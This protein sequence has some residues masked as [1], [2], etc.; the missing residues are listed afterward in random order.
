MALYR[1]EQARMSFSSEAAP[2]GYM[3]I[4]GITTDA[5][6]WTGVMNNTVLASGTDSAS[7]TAAFLTDTTAS[8]ITAGVVPG[9]TILNTTDTSTG[10]IISLTANTVVA[11]MSSGTWASGDG[12]SIQ[13]T[14]LP[15]SRSVTFDGAS[16]TLAV[17]NY[18][19]LG[20]AGAENAEIRR[21]ISLGSYGG[22]A[23]T[24][25][26]F[27]D[28]PTGFPHV[29]NSLVDEK[30]NAFPTGSTYTAADTGGSPQGTAGD[31][32][33]NFA[34]FLPGVYESI[35]TPDLTPEFLPQYFLRDSNTRNWSYMYRGKQSF[36][37]SL[38]NILLLNGQPLK[39]PFG[40]VATTAGTKSN[41]D[42]LNGGT[43]VGDRVINLTSGTGYTAGKW[44][45]IDTDASNKAEVRQIL[46]LST[47]TLTLNYPLM[48]THADGVA[49]YEA[50]GVYTHTM[51]E[52]AKLPTMTWNVLM[53][54][55]DE[56][57]DNDFIRR[58][59]GGICN[60]ATL[61]GAEG[62]MLRYSWDDVQFMDLVH[63]QTRHSS[64]TGDSATADLMANSSSMLL[65]PLGIGADMPY[66]VPATGNQVL[67]TP[68]YPRTEPYYFSQG[69]LSFFGVEFARIV[70]FSLQIS[71][72]VEAKYYVSD[73]GGKRIPSEFIEKNR[74]Y[75]M[76]VSIAL[77]DSFSS[78]STTKSLWKELILEG[79]YRGNGVQALMGFD[80]SLT[81]T[82]DTNE[83]ITIT[84]PSSNASTSFDSQGCFF[85]RATHN[86]DQE[87]PL[88]VD[89]E[90]IMRDCKVV[91]ID[92]IPVYA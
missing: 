33:I 30:T 10:V 57:A 16:G 84:S 63:N 71:N 21:V 74:D 36:A 61:S 53:R 66:I 22:T 64:V 1:A 24:G 23:A 12:Y 77:P 38:S 68:V 11:T 79:N 7:S 39:Y 32:G 17:G 13:Q 5:G 25:T 15:G 80:M 73:K 19:L 37:G 55:S 9:D 44:I 45:Q 88:Q 83:T 27:L 35:T 49:T 70:N 54:D 20:T 41:T 62:E 82:R 60:Q 59:V 78:S 87:S 92:A 69:T 86:I 58:Y 29:T 42:S 52:D 3:E 4:I 40:A 91:V 34:T 90:I 26:I 56:T 28:Y 14:M 50:S 18:I 8:F 46:V 43:V 75:R 47:N 81:F 67:D 76:S 2:G 85:S 31:G 6:D 48:I 65:S 89:G 51:Q 72:N